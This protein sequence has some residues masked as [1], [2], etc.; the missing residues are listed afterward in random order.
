MPPPVIF[1]SVILT[2]S[3]AYCYFGYYF[4]KILVLL[5]MFI[6][7][8]AEG[9]AAACPAAHPAGLRPDRRSARPL[10]GLFS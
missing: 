5:F 6:S 4:F 8:C 1:I 7:L 2:H 10:Y 3:D 9:H